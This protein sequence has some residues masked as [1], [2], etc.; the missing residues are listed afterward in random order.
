MAVLSSRSSL[1]ALLLLVGAARHF[2]WLLAEPELR[3]IASK[4]LGAAAILALLCVVIYTRRSLPILAVCAWWIV[5]EV[6]VILC[7]V[8]WAIEPWPVP[9]GAAMC[10][11]RAGLDLGAISIV[12]V[13]GLAWVVTC[14]R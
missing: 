13:A 3:G 12:V 8:L 14:K 5:E 6:Q 2:G 9:V 7:S 4:G 11:A 1:P 10:S